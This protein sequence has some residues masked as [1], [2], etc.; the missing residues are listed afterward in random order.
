MIVLRVII[1]QQIAKATE[2]RER[3]FEEGSRKMW[4]KRVLGK[5]SKPMRI[6]HCWVDGGNGVRK[7]CGNAVEIMKSVDK[8]FCAWTSATK[9][10]D[11]SELTCK[12]MQEVYSENK[13]EKLW[14]IPTKGF[15]E[16]Y[17]HDC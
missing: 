9:G 8:H 11:D 10:R 17:S 2:D 12:E 13:S 14:H 1:Q 3:M 5:A 4:L 7:L 6:N 15:P 16:G